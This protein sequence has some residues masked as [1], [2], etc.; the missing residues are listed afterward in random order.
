MPRTG[1]LSPR[2]QNA[3]AD[4]Y[5]SGLTEGLRLAAGPDHTLSPG[6]AAQFE[7]LGDDSRLACVAER[8]RRG[9]G[10]VAVM[11]GSISAGSTYSASWGDASWLYASKIL[12]SMRVATALA[13]GNTLPRV[14]NRAIPAT[15]PEFFDL[16]FGSMLPPE[17]PA[18]LVIIEFT[19]NIQG[20]VAA[21]ERL[22]RRVLMRGAAV[23][24]LSAKAWATYDARGQQM[25]ARRGSEMKCWRLPDKPSEKEADARGAPLQGPTHASGSIR[26][27]WLSSAPNRLGQTWNATKGDIGEEDAIAAVCRHY[28]VPL[29]SYRAAL[30]GAVRAGNVSFESFMQDCKHPNGQGHTYFAQLVL[31]RLF[32]RPRG[33]ICR[34]AGSTLP[35]PTLP[36]ALHKNGHVDEHDQTA[37]CASGTELTPLLARPPLGFE[38][39][40]EGRGKYGLVATRVG[41]AA[42]LCVWNATSGGRPPKLVHVGYLKSYAG[43]MGRAALSCSGSCACRPVEFDGLDRR[44]HASV[45]AFESLPLRQIGD[46]ACCSVQVRV[47]ANSSTDGHKVKLLSVSTTKVSLT[48]KRVLSPHGMKVT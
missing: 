24:V 48:L 4:A 33:S 32:H 34:A 21:F 31:A 42:E 38:L 6:L 19:V 29:V 28:N 13:G 20:D 3:K 26:R 18:D 14:R 46:A 2:L 15:G 44:R 8:L 17:W 37:L 43:G 10:T 7:R 22:L 39:T 45:A 23:I 5:I 1:G 40:D 16:C 41:A 35:V 11:G 27:A 30:L 25:M 47:L 12:R 9:R 36:A